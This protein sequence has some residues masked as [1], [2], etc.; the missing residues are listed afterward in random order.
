M[1]LQ[2]CSKI[3][4]LAALGFTLTAAGAFY[5]LISAEHTID[6][7]YQQELKERFTAV[8]ADLNHYV[9]RI[10]G[11]YYELI[12]SSLSNI[13]AL[14]QSYYRKDPLLNFFEQNIRTGGAYSSGE[15]L[16]Y[17]LEGLNYFG[18]PYIAYNLDSKELTVHGLK[19]HNDDESTQHLLK[20]RNQNG[21]TL[22]EMISEPQ[23]LA[24]S[25]TIFYSGSDTYL[26]LRLFDQDTNS[27]YYIVSSYLEVL[28][29][30]ALNLKKVF[31][32]IDPMLQGILKD[33]AVMI[34][35]R[36][37]PILKSKDFDLALDMSSSHLRELIGVRLIDQDG[38]L[39][40]DA[41]TVTQ[42]HQA[43]ILAVSYVRSI[44]SYLLVK[45]P[46]DLIKSD[47]SLILLAKIFTIVLSLLS[48]GL[49]ARVALKDNQGER[50]KLKTLSLL[51]HKLNDMSP[52]DFKQRL[53]QAYVD[54][55]PQAANTPNSDV[56]AAGAAATSATAISA[57]SAA[58][59]SSN[60]NEADSTAATDKEQ[61]ANV[62]VANAAHDA[63]SASA[64]DVSGD[65]ASEVQAEA[66]R[67]IEPEGSNN[68]SAQ[69][70]LTNDSVKDSE[71]Q[72]SVGQQA[73]D[74]TEKSDAA[75]A[76]Q[77]S[78]QDTNTD[79]VIDADAPVTSSATDATEKASA[80]LS[81]NALS[82]DSGT[83]DSHDSKPADSKAN[84]ESVAT[85]QLSTIKP[86]DV[87]AKLVM[88]LCQDDNLDEHSP[89]WQMLTAVVRLAQSLELNSNEQL[90]ELK[91]EFKARI[92]LYRK[93]GQC[94]AA[95]QMLLNALPSEESMPSSNFVDFAAFTVPA[96][97]LSGNFYTIQRL[98]D[99]NLA[100][101]IG[102]CESSGTKAAYTVAVV[103][104]L[105]SEALKLDLDPPHVMQYLNERLCTIPHL[106]PVSLFIGMISEKTGNVIAANAGHC[107]PIV[108][109]DTGPH[110]VAPFNEQRL[111]INKEQN[112]ELVKWYL[113]NDDMVMLYSKGILNVKNAAGEIFGMDRLLDHCV[114]ANA[115]Q[116]DELVIKI[117]N[118][119]KQHKG[120]R[121]FRE[122]V[123]LI[124]LK[125]LRIRF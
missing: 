58:E 110:F 102:D 33:D 108:V 76:A 55:Q 93:E 12:N 44:N 37:Q 46:F 9:Q 90:E 38:N 48:V 40:E 88:E 117:L 70:A 45:R 84:M 111:G 22:E 61:T 7:N 47:T 124:C 112:F 30:I 14:D 98:D 15:N 94:I 28:D 101:V 115:L 74:S 67:A 21:Q 122:D 119:I 123:S 20:A 39:L 56:T 105:V 25:F 59:V 24:Q 1:K 83:T 11:D 106:S 80:S 75:D 8:G 62:E 51:V 19:D 114:G 82:H 120:K 3:I 36:G 13:L 10:N 54:L 43:S 81:V 69:G 91:Q 66:K 107:V 23:T 73:S 5:S 95:R 35:R 71:A 26:C 79:H 104:I 89:T 116:A 29:N 78:A 34:V 31:S 86:E 2:A 65:T 103:S 63:P 92:P 121:P 85:S 4:T 32:D 6:A 60:N 50:R 109:D 118:D 64:E 52:A 99:D 53:Q 49:I 77:S 41:S 96:R 68:S 87:T 16:V 97:E 42:E 100:F 72:A 57:D 125:Q 17:A 18:V 27:N 113:A